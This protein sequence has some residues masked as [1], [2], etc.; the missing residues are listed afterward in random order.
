MGF[1][2]IETDEKITQP[3]APAKDMDSLMLAGCT[4]FVGS[5]MTGY[6]LA[7][8][9]FFLFAE[10][11]FAS[12]LGLALLCGIVPALIF[13]G[14]VTRKFGLPAAC[15]SLG[16]GMATS[17]FIYLRLNQIMLANGVP[18]AEKPNYPEAW[19]W[20]IPLATLLLTIGVLAVLLPKGEFGEAD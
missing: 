10:T 19:S 15:G 5:S 1:D 20:I 4:G 6:V 16:G 17:V 2:P 14:Y 11:R 7:V 9:P 3:S 8:W 18:Q 12:Q 13:A